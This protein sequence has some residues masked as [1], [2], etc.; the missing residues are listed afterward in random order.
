MQIW[1]REWFQIKESKLLFFGFFSVLF[2][3]GKQR[4][5]ILIL[6]GWWLNVWQLWRAPLQMLEYKQG[7]ANEQW[8][9]VFPNRTFGLKKGVTLI[10]RTVS[11]FGRYM[12][13]EKGCLLWVPNQEFWLLFPHIQSKHRNCKQE[14]DATP[15]FGLNC[16][17][18]WILRSSCP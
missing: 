10:G 2:T 16:A 7:L 6:T 5:K 15:L 11:M 8:H 9:Q 17:K 4:G 14:V 3:N 18:G 12:V 1:H 13:T